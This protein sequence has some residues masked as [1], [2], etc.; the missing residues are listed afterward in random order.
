MAKTDEAVNGGTPMR[1]RLVVAD[2]RTANAFANM[3]QRRLLLALVAQELSLQELAR[4]LKL[5]LSLAHYHVARL[6][7]LGVVIMTR[8]QSRAGRV[9]KHYRACARSFFVPAHLASQSAGKELAAELRASLEHA[10]QRNPSDGTLYFIDD[11]SLP[12]MQRVQNPTRAVVASEYWHRLRLTNEDARLLASELKALFSRFES[13]TNG[14]AKSYLAYCALA[15]A[16]NQRRRA[17]A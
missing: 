5:S 1:D 12:R 13:G 7:E 4:S 10:Q 15:P 17:K 3:R 9:I 14:T 6:L 8:E 11:Q 16:A 2:A